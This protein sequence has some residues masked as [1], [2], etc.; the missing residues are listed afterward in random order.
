M[1]TL[2]SSTS[3]RAILNFARTAISS[4]SCSS[5]KLCHISGAS[6]SRPSRRHY[7][8]SPGNP[9]SSYF[10]RNNPSSPFGVPEPQGLGHGYEIGRWGDLTLSEKVM[11]A[12]RK[13]RDGIIFLV[14][15]GLVGL[16][17]YTT[18]SE[19]VAHNSPTKLFNDAADRV[20]ADAEL[21]SILPHPLKFL[22]PQSSHSRR[23]NHRVATSTMKDPSTGRESLIL[24]FMIEA[25]PPTSSH[26]ASEQEWFFVRW[27]NQLLSYIPPLPFTARE[28]A[29]GEEITLPPPPP[30]PPVEEK[31]SWIEWWKSIFV[32]LLRGFIPSLGLGAGKGERK[33]TGGTEILRRKPRFA[34][35][36]TGECVA[37]FEQNTHGDFKYKS[38]WVDIPN[39]QHAVYR[40]D[41][42]SSRNES[43]AK[44]ADS[45]TGLGRLKVWDKKPGDRYLH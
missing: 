20:K 10:P 15:F 37:Q 25:S 8:S 16:V 29:R 31:P 33:S 30:P 39:S 34:Q 1:Q 18:L 43:G 45:G 3:G 4:P 11:R 36:L 23:R 21:R 35:Y 28:F 42:L 13:G 14:G 17:G 7:S 27:Y 38:L 12:G 19:L 40:V 5:S 41:I 6:L 24:H 32:D 9:A 2:P 26:P 44:D 22:A